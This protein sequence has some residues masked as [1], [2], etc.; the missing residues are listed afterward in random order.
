M[1]KK[2][3]DIIINET[4]ALENLLALL[5]EQYVYIMKKDVFS[6]EEVIEK[7]KLSNQQI[8]QEEVNRRKLVGNKPMREI[9]NE[10][11]NEDLVDEYRKVKKIITLVKQQKET[12]E[13]LIKQQIGF[14][15]QILN[16]IN[17][18]RDVKTYT[19]MGN[20]SR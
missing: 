3:V 10:S 11:K 17:P 7:I 13:L 8:A 19:S 4:N 1:D 9:I 15:T 6:I 14:N 5:Q 18:R 2:L 12:N 20:L 16:L